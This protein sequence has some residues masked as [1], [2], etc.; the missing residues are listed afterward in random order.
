M[1]MFYVSLKQPGQ[2]MENGSLIFILKLK[3]DLF[4]NKD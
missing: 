1:F 3:I 2:L 4:L